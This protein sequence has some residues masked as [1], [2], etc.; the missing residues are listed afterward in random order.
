MKPPVAG[1]K[2]DTLRIHGVELIDNYSWLRDD[3]RKNAEVLNYL[4]AEN[5]FTESFKNY[6]LADRIYHEL[7]TRIDENDTSVPYRYD[8]YYYYSRQEKDKQYPIYCRKKGSLDAEEEIILDM[9]TLSEGKKFSG[10]GTFKIS[11]NHRFLAYSIDDSGMESYKLYIKDLF[12]NE[13]I[14]NVL[15]GVSGISWANDNKTIFLK[16]SSFVLFYTFTKRKSYV[17]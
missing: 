12:T 2:P 14:E 11:P 9:N 3:Y 17:K 8:Y 13:I 15:D 10:L 1:I 5:E 16:L 6:S 7:I 4:K